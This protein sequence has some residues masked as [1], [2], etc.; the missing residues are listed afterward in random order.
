MIDH[1]TVATVIDWMIEVTI[2]VLI[3]FAIYCVV[4][5]FPI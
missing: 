5:S 1:R 4:F 3:V 2:V